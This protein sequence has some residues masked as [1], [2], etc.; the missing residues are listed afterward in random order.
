[1]QRSVLGTTYTSALLRQE[2][3]ICSCLRSAATNENL[4][5]YSSNSHF[6]T[7][8]KRVAMHE[9]S[10]MQAT[11]TPQERKS[12]KGDPVCADGV[13]DAVSP[14]ISMPIESLCGDLVGANL[15]TEVGRRVHVQLA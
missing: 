11:L 5:A 15:D 2:A 12:P 3:D 7:N 14:R 8:L 6:V 10:G 13:Q 4:G 9:T 1:M